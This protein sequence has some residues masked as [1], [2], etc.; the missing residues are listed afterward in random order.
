EERTMIFYESPFR[1]ARTLKDLAEHFGADRMACVSREIS[2]IHEENRRDS[3]SALKEHYEQHP[4]K[5]EIVLVVAGSK[6]VKSVERDVEE[7]E[8]D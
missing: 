6:K 3:L 7:E 2:K 5:G 4:P 8:M 1:L